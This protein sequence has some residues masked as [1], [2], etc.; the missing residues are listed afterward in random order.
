[1]AFPKGVR[2]GFVRIAQTTE[3]AP[4]GVREF[5]VAGKTLAVANVAGKFYAINNICI[6]RGGPLGQG[7]LEGMLVTCP[8]HGWRYDVSTGKASHN[9]TA[10]VA[11]YPVDV[12]G[13]EVFVDT[14]EA[15]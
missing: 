4:G 14:G 5:Q 13:G 6:H 10:G 7:S 8:W 11:C 15:A 3:I 12:R 9:Q 1:M 2:M